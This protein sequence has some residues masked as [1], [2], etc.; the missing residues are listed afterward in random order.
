MGLYETL[1]AAKIGAAPDVL[2]KLRAQIAPFAKGGYIEK[3]LTDTPPLS[4]TANGDDLIAYTIYGN[5][6]QSET[7]STSSPVYPS[8]CGNLVESGTHSGEY[9]LSI[10]SGNVTRP[11]YLTEPIRKIGESIDYKSDSAEY[12][13][14]KKLVLTGQE[15]WQLQSIN[16]NGIANFYISFS[17]NRPL[18]SSG[19]CSH[20]VRQTTTISNTTT[21]GFLISAPYT[22]YIRFDSTEA[23]TT[24][25]FKQWLA[26]QYTNG[27]PVTVW[28][29]LSEPTT[30][31]VEGPAIPT[32]SG[33]NALSVGTTVQPSSVYIKYKE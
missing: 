10:T 12:R 16:D 26:D 23:G 27:M 3:E 1:K 9:N 21:Q 15:N 28:Y 13:V 5:M 4:F 25:E 18:N 32:V 7:P 31:T 17:T 8:E 29:I 2:T 22:L 24:E 11:I 14:I 6:S 30:T 19:I 20:F 33:S